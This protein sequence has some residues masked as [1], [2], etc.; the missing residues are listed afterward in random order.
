VFTLDAAPRINKASPFTTGLAITLGNR[1]A[2][3]V[4]VFGV[5]WTIGPQSA[6]TTKISAVGAFESKTA[7]VRLAGVAPWVEQPYSLTATL[8]DGTVLTQHGTISF[9]PIESGATAH[10]PPIDLATDGVA[11]YPGHPYGGVSDLSGIARLTWTANGLTV[12]ADIVDNV[13][14]PPTNAGLLYL[15]D[16]IQLAVSPLRPGLTASRVEIGLA[17]IDGQAQAFV[18]APAPGQPAG[19]LSSPGASVVRTGNHTVYAITLDWATLGLTG[20]PTDLFAC[21]LLVN[22]D[23]TDGGP[24]GYVEW[25]AGIAQGKNTALMKTVQIVP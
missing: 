19:A 13:S 20:P 18:F 16:S 23:D 8:S 7:L 25:G 3:R 24:R 12:N 10:L 15:N 14:S 1:S 21:S 9:N 17:Q 11:T 22:D 6:T 2:Q 5:D 4:A